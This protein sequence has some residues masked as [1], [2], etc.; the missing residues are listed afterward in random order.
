MTSDEQ[1]V[2]RAALAWT[3]THTPPAL[4]WGDTSTE[5]EKEL[6][7]ACAALRASKE[8]R[9]QEQAKVEGPKAA[10]SLVEREDGRCLAVWNRRYHGWSL[11]GGKVESG[12]T[13][14]VAQARELEEETGMLTSE[15]ELVY[16]GPTCVETATDR[17]R[18]VYLFR[19]EA[20]GEPREM[21]AGSP[22]QWMTREEFLAASPFAEFYQKAFAAVPMVQDELL[23]HAARATGRLV[24]VTTYYDGV[25]PVKDTLTFRTTAEAVECARVLKRAKKP[26][27]GG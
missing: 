24:Q 20:T 7:V 5:D 18:H 1:R 22:V 19:V 23:V 21:E 3:E 16:D 26:L 10:V 15:R 17:G 11:P 2:V 13:L 9:T 25:T 12:E 27:G 14:E 6:F 8:R 4:T